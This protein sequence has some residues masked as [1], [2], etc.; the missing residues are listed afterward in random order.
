MVT[1]GAATTCMD[2]A[3]NLFLKSQQVELA[4]ATR[5]WALLHLIESYAVYNYNSQHDREGKSD[6]IPPCSTSNERR[7]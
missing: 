5:D 4:L 7:H 1:K 6:L 3:E 2:N